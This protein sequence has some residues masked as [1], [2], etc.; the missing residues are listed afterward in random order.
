[1]GTKRLAP[2]VVK[3]LKHQHSQIRRGFVTALLPGP[4]QQRRFD[5]LRTLLAVHEAAEEA[6]VHPV[7]KKATGKAA[8]V[9]GARL[10]E[11]KSAKQ[12]L[13]GLERKRAGT[14]AYTAGL[15][16]LAVAVS[17][18]ARHEE[19]REFPLLRRGVSTPRLRMLGAESI[20]TQLIAPTRAH[21][22][23]NGQLP[24]KLVAPVMGPVDRG[25]DLAMTAIRRIR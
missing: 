13:H 11:E 17:R 20:L 4:G 23:V 21:P 19:R 14:P 6:H 7:A 18:H 22:R 3:L 24:N 2:D 9:I 16:R 12:L 15:L 1:M 10:A 25:R 8:R 5:R